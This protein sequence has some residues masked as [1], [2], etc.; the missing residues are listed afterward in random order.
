MKDMVKV[1][2]SSGKRIGERLI[3]SLILSGLF[4]EFL[5]IFKLIQAS[6]SNRIMALGML[7]GTLKSSF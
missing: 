7:H 4:R 3:S 5:S 6:N 1:L 2:E